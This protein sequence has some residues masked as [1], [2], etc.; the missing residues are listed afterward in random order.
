MPTIQFGIHIVRIDIIAYALLARI[1][2]QPWNTW[3][4]VVRWRQY[5]DDVAVASSPPEQP[6]PNAVQY[7]QYTYINIFIRRVVRH[8]TY[9]FIC[10]RHRLGLTPRTNK[11]FTKLI[12]PPQWL[13]EFGRPILIVRRRSLFGFTTYTTREGKIY[14]QHVSTPQPL[15]KSA[16]GLDRYKYNVTRLL[17]YRSL[18]KEM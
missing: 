12:P 15:L 16:V 4:E 10:H 2:G 7:I 17:Q 18:Y 8:Q 11:P 5:D 1:F 6:P 13:A 14:S 9:I 3:S